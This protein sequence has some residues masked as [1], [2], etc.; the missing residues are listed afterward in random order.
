VDDYIARLRIAAKPA[1]ARR[2]V[3]VMIAH[4]RSAGTPGVT[5]K[6][7][8]TGAALLPLLV[9]KALAASVLR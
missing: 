9:Y 8:L 7:A 1:R 3:S 6:V 5:V 2:A 4:P